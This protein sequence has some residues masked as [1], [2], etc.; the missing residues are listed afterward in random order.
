MSFGSPYVRTRAGSPIPVTTW[1]N[2]IAVVIAYGCEPACVAGAPSA[3]LTTESSKLSTPKL[4]TPAASFAH[5]GPA[6]ANAIPVTNDTISNPTA[7]P[8]AHQRRIIVRGASARVYLHEQSL[9]PAC[10]TASS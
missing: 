5:A 8:L 1:L 4:S 7:N 2:V 6:S 3:L 10:H 9:S